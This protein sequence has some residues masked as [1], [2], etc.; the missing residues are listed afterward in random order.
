MQI[1]VID[2][3]DVESGRGIFD[4]VKFEQT[5]PITYVHAPG[6]NI[7]IARN[8]AI[9]HASGDWMA[10]VD[11]DVFVGKEWL[12]NLV[13]AAGDADVV[14]GS[15][16][17]TYD[18]EAPSWIAK[19]DLHSTF[20]SG[21]DGN[22]NGSTCNVLIRR[23]FVEDNGLRFNT[24]FGRSGGEDTLFFT[25]AKGAG[26]RFASTSEIHAFEL[27]PAARAN[28]RWL[29]ARRW[30]YGKIH[31]A[32]RVACG[33]SPAVYLATLKAVWCFAS[34]ALTFF[35]RQKAFK[36]L[37]RGVLHAGV[38]AAALGAKKT[39]AYGS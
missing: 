34:A 2:N 23:S 39:D 8:A 26:G 36:S 21:Q 37:L 6:R 25:Q 9:D 7:S 20:A 32:V 10:F 13:N 12:Q 31:F 4:R 28:I 17:A 1:L 18:A 11:D 27:V 22:A 14:F 30:R 16:K 33:D 15:T 24:L 19:S 29:I 3:D 35:N 38:V 5:M